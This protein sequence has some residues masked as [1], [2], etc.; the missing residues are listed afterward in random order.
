M[1]DVSL[2]RKVLFRPFAF[3]LSQGRQWYPYE[4]IREQ[5]Y[6]NNGLQQVV[7]SVHFVKIKTQLLQNTM[8]SNPEQ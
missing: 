5:W 7:T 4:H 1:N 2:V 3:M 8:D 6:Y